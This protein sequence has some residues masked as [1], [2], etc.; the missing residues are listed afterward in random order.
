MKKSILV[1]VILV[2]NISC[3]FY[4]P[5]K[6]EYVAKTPLNLTLSG[7]E[8]R[9]AIDVI[10]L[11]QDEKGILEETNDISCKVLMD[12]IDGR[13]YYKWYDYRIRAYKAGESVPDWEPYD[14]AE[15]FDYYLIPVSEDGNYLKNLPSKD[16]IPNDLNGLKFYINLIDFHMWALLGE[17][18]LNTENFLPELEKPSLSAV[19]DELE[20][21]QGDEEINLTGSDGI[22][23]DLNQTIGRMY[24]KYIGEAVIGSEDTRI[25]F[26]LQEQKLIQTIF[27]EM[28]IMPYEGTNRFSG[29]LYYTSERKLKQA[30]YTE[31]VYGKVEAPM[32]LKVITHQERQYSIRELE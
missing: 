9:Y 22:S 21:D 2:L 20:I 30:E 13:H 5:G 29:Y 1:L 32:F 7:N 26:Y 18:F 28:L 24:G 12:E 23:S 8:I 3:E 17:V 16:Y 15:N 27:A 19:G 6:S 11:M 10:Y 4:F 31:Y 14:P 25:I